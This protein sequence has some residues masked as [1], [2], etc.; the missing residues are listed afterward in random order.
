MLVAAGRTG[1]DREVFPL[2]QSCFAPSGP[3]RPVKAPLVSRLLE[4]FIHL[5]VES[6]QQS[7]PGQ[8]L[9]GSQT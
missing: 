2:C 8:N 7:Y 9:R 3:V 1:A 4:N 6:A 5:R